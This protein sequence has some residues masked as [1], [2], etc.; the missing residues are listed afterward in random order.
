MGGFIVVMSLIPKRARL[1]T[2][3][4]VDGSLSTRAQWMPPLGAYWSITSTQHMSS[5]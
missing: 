5:L 1:T 2:V 3:P 4:L